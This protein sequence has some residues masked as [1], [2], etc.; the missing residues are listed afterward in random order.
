MKMG[1]CLV[2]FFITKLGNSLSFLL[3]ILLYVFGKITLQKELLATLLTLVWS[4]TGVYGS[5]IFKTLLSS[6][7]LPAFAKLVAMGF[8]LFDV[9][10]F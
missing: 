6:E 7:Y 8:S 3:M 1:T 9:L 2:S 10:G 5:V 4:L